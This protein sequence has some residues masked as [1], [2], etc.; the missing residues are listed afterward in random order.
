M[1]AARTPQ[2]QPIAPS[3]MRGARNADTARRAHLLQAHG[4][5]DPAAVEVAP[6]ADDIAQIDTDAQAQ[7]VVVRPPVILARQFVL[8]GDGASH[9]AADAIERDQHRIARCLHHA[10]TMP[11]DRRP[12]QPM[13]AAQPCDGSGVVAMKQPAVANKVGIQS[14]HQP[15]SGP[16]PP[17][18]P[19]CRLSRNTLG[20]RRP[21]IAGTGV[22][23]R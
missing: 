18:Q 21:V 7:G 17:R 8:H 15:T 12:D 20:W 5:D 22:P 4:D 2:A 10:T 1:A 19:T 13:H 9:R 6:V 16:A 23:E 11:T 14:G 3:L